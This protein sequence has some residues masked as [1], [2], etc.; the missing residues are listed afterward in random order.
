MEIDKKK[1]NLLLWTSGWD[2]TFRLLELVCLKKELVQPIYIIDEDRKSLQN[3]LNSIEKITKA[4]HEKYPY[5]KE[6]ILP[7]KYYSKKDI[8]IK[9]EIK[10]AFEHIRNFIKI[11]SQYDWI[12]SLCG[13]EKLKD[14]EL[15]IFKNERTDILFNYINSEESIVAK[16]LFNNEETKTKEAIQLIFKHYLFPVLTIDK[17]D[18][19]TTAKQNDWMEIMKLTWFCHRPKKGKPCGKCNPCSIAIIEGLG[20]RIPFIN[21]QKGYFKIFIKKTKKVFK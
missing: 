20:F 17:M 19:Y 2:S 12:S 8:I 15:C 18:M 11:G 6:L 16:D 10:A 7:I 9:P 21:R 5:S 3:E 13:Q 1:A 14:V 4:I